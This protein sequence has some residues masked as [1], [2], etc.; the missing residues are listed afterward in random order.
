[1]K[2][3]HII[4]FGLLGLTHATKLIPIPTPVIPIQR[5]AARH[6]EKITSNDELPAYKSEK[7]LQADV[8]H[9]PD[10]FIKPCKP[11]QKVSDAGSGFIAA[12]TD[13]LLFNYTL[14]DFIF[15]RDRIPLKSQRWCGGELDFTSDGC[16]ESLDNPFGFSFTD[17]CYRHDFG[18]QNYRLQKRFTASNKNRIDRNFHKDLLGRCRGHVASYS[19]NALAQLYFL[20]VQAYGG[21]D[22]KEEE[23]V[24]W[25]P[26]TNRTQEVER[27]A[28][29]IETAQKSFERA[30]HDDQNCGVLPSI[31]EALLK[32]RFN[33]TKPAAY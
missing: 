21:R 25:R 24:A 23:K 11:G 1:M 10:F 14:N 22:A 13:E 19:C 8:R 30:V 28:R 33:S 27:L 3:S 32:I 29:E 20:G 17:A 4:P 31:D 6:E 16:T 12:L 5:R 2:F 15:V 7:M 18:Y 26:N 9:P